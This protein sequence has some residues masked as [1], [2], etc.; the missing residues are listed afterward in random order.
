MDLLVRDN[1]SRIDELEVFI[2]E[3]P[4]VECPV[5]HR[6]TKGMYI[7]EIFMPKNSLITSK[8]HLTNH[9][10]VI[11]KGSVL[12]QIDMGE[13]VEMEAPFTG[14]TVGGTRRVLFVQED[15]V[16]VTFH[17]IDYITGDENEL[18]EI[19]KQDIVD[20]IEKLIIEPHVNELLYN[21]KNKIQ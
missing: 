13:W 8:I 19:E 5:I 9:P 20:G 21:T 3:L 17:P 2:K 11:S 1:D 16:W 18:M 10:F 15:T 6:F 12:V 14:I 7:R 4:I